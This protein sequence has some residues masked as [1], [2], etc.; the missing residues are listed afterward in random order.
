MPVSPP[1]PAHED[2]PEDD[3]D[4]RSRDEW[5]GRAHGRRQHQEDGDQQQ[6]LHDL[7]GR[8]LPHDS[9]HGTADVMHLTAVTDSAMDVAGDAAR[10]HEVEEHRPVIG[11]DGGRQ[12]EAVDRLYPGEERTGA[13]TPDHDREHRKG[14]SRAGP[15]TETSHGTT[16]RSEWP[17]VTAS[18]PAAASLRRRRR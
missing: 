11:G 15:P 5:H 17:T 16:S 8:A 6:N 7:P 14:E 1:H 10:E 12:S 2:E 13:E 3:R 9:A 18:T 4:R